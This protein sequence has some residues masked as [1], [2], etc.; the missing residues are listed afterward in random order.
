MRELRL[1]AAPAADNAG[2]VVISAAAMAEYL[3][4]HRDVAPAPSAAR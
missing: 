4:R 3:N 1:E 2:R